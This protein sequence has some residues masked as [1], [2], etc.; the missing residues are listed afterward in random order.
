MKT[1]IFYKADDDVVGIRADPD[2]IDDLIAVLNSLL[3]IAHTVKRKAR[4]ES[5]QAEEKRK[6]KAALNLAE[7]QAEAVNVYRRYQEHLD[8]GCNG[9]KSLAIQKIKQEFKMGYT[10]A[11]IYI[12]EGRKAFRQKKALARL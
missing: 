11:D 9:Q 2:V 10:D 4:Y 3:S 5:A 12:S 8:N 1:D 6:K 7:F